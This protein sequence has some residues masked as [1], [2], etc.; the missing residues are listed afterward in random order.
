M[1]ACIMANIGNRDLICDGKEI[2]PARSEGKKIS[3]NLAVSMSNLT[4]PIISPVVNWIVKNY[5]DAELDLVL[6]CTKQQDEKHRARDTVYF[7][8]CISKMLSGQKPFRKVFKVEIRSNPNLYDD[9]FELFQKE[10]SKRSKNLSEYDQIFI[11][12]AGGI[13]ACNMALCFHSISF[14]QEKAVPVYP[15]EGKNAAV[16]LQIGEQLINNFKKSSIVDYLKQYDYAAVIPMLEGLGMI[17]YG[18]LVEAALAR[19]SFNFDQA[20]N[21]L[22][23]IINRQRG[24]IRDFALSVKADLERLSMGELNLLILELLHN[25][26]IKFIRGEYIDFLGRVHR[27]AEAVLRYIVED[28]SILGIHTDIDP[29]GSNFKQFNESMSQVPGL[30]GFL[31]LKKY[32]SEPLNYK[33][34]YIPTLLAILEFI[35][36]KERSSDLP[37]LYERISLLDNLSSLRNRSPLAHGFEGV[38]LEKIIEKIPGFSFEYLVE[39]VKKLNIADTD[40]PFEKVSEFVLKKLVNTS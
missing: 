38:S 22:D 33:Q 1:K 15:L 20:I 19:L 9:M 10:I 7:A 11:S 39:I 14:F 8:E 6:F 27:F 5:P 2:S 23:G 40:D 29:D 26:R 18:R 31:R 36:I 32:G 13:P 37:F 35:K 16:P 3:N 24:E 17:D 34:P 12:L 30:V 21:L 4:M 25:S 28:K